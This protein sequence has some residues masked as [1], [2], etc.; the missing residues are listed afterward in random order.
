M[1]ALVALTF[2]VEGSQ[3]AHAHDTSAA[4]LFDGD[5]PL[6]AL[7]AVH[8]ASPLPE[9]PLATWVALAGDAPATV[10]CARPSP[11]AVRHTD[12]RAPPTPLA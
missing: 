6:A 7:A 11:S 8:G 9:S 3:P 12:P 5:C 1:L 10:P 4:A 2:A